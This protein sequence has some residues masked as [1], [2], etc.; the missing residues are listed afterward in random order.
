M[1]IVGKHIGY[2]GQITFF[3]KNGQE[4]FSMLVQ[5]IK[6]AKDIAAHIPKMNERDFRKLIEKEHPDKFP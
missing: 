4:Y 6:G 3:C 2:N 1:T 5:N